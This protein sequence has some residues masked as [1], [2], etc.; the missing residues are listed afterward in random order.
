MDHQ[1]LYIQLGRTIETMPNLT[2]TGPY[3]P[4]TLKWLARAN[5]LVD[6]C[7]DIIDAAS[8]RVEMDSA[9]THIGELADFGHR[10]LSA[11]KLES[12]LYRRLAVA[13]LRA[14]ASSQGA[15]IPAG[16]ELDAYAAFAKMAETAKADLLIVDPYMD[17]ITLTDFA[18]TAAENVNIRLLGAA[19][20]I[21]ATLKPA[22]ERW[23]KQYGKSRPL[24]ARLATATALHDRVFLVDGSSA[25]LSTQSLNAIAKR[26]PATIT[27]V[28][29]E[30]AS[31]K[32]AS[33]EAIW[34][35]SKKM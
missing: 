24:E 19:E 26:S 12:I 22:V 32:I 35:A 21:K 3:P 2:M 16:N 1:A 34:A 28:D 33:Y 27:R 29:G 25:W 30:M 17:E 20:R 14:P 15:F 4:D 11:R 13:E 7:D 23:K 5:A 6:T 31:M 9:I 18:A 10:A 8:F